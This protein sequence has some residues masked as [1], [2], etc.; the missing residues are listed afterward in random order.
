LTITSIS[1]LQRL[2]LLRFRDMIRVQY[3]N[4]LFSAIN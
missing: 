3:V 4:P 2:Y 1:F